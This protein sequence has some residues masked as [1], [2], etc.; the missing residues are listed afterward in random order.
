MAD[1]SSSARL[2]QTVLSPSIFSSEE[3]IA[4]VLDSIAKDLRD[5]WDVVARP[6]VG[7]QQPGEVVIF[8]DFCVAGLISP[9][10]EFF[11]AILEVYGLHMLHLPPNAVI[12]LSLFAYVCEAYVGVMLSAALFRHYFTPPHG[13]I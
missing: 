1:R 2:T 10:S 13:Q 12:I 9:F 5:T 7:D 4:E 11:M 3:S 6:A 8:H